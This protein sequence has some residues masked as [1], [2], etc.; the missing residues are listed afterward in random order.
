VQLV[1]FYFRHTHL[2][3]TRFDITALKGGGIL[4][5][6]KEYVNLNIHD[7]EE[8]D[9]PFKDQI[10]RYSVPRLPWHDVNAVIYGESARDLARHFIQRWNATKAEKFR[11]GKMVSKKS[12]RTTLLEKV[13]IFII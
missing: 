10:D 13:A 5:P 6:G 12:Y 3:N 11:V 4:Y 8:V 2:Q 7:F 9:K 1:I